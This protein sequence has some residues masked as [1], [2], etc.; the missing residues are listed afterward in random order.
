M[1]TGQGERSVKLSLRHRM[2]LFFSFALSIIIAVF[3]SVILNYS[4][5]AF[6][7]QS[8]AYCQQI[9]ESNIGLM[10]TYFGQ[11]KDVSMIIANDADVIEAVNYRNSTQRVDYGK[12]LY[13]QRK[14]TDKMKQI[15]VL[16]NVETSLI[17]GNRYQC[18][19]SYGTSPKRNYNFKDQKWFLDAI[20]QNGY[21]AH[22][23]DYHDTDYLLSGTHEKNISVITPILNTSQYATTQAAYFLCD[24]QLSSVIS[25]ARPGSNVSVAVY[26]GRTPV[27][28][29]DEIRLTKEQKDQLSGSLAQGK[30]S[31][32]L[33]DAAQSYL[34]VNQTS[35]V[36]GWS[37]L[38]LM[39]LTAIDSLRFSVSSFVVAAILISIGAV[40]V[41]SLLISKSILIPIDRLVGSFNQI[42]RGKTDVS[43]Q[44][45]GSRE[46]NLLAQTA[47]EMLERINLLSRDLIQKQKQFSQEQLKVLQHQINPHFLNNT[48]QSIKSLAVTGNMN[49]VSRIATLLGRLLSYSVYEPFGKVPLSEELQH[50]ENYIILQKARYPNIDYSVDCEKTVRNVLVPKLIVQPLVENAIEHGLSGNRKG[51][52]S[53]CAEADESEI[54]VIVADSGTGFSEE[55]R[56]EVTARLQNGDSGSASGN[57]GLLNVHKRIQSIY[58][59]PYGISILSRAGMNT[60]VIITI[61]RKEEEKC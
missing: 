14:V 55:K 48:L 49:A 3:G 12:E 25:G 4:I 16:G 24:F 21:T 59:E 43:F 9:V 31:F 37:I 46:V 53:V 6:R 38:G 2:I 58:G 27:Y 8:D 36:S 35:K 56:K 34:V 29:P 39:P 13:Y 23:T 1:T 11:I 18:L 61:P 44:Q 51:H 42:A 57:I 22:F 45:S 20:R 7:S 52:I 32:T 26:D 19:Y 54:H 50:A 17:V 33:S 30:R 5:N 47:Q 28:F 10:D 15:D 60:S 41:L 40:V